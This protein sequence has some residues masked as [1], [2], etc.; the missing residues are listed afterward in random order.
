MAAG[1]S[2]RLAGDIKPWAGHVP[3]FNR[4]FDA[5]V[6]PAC[7][8]HRG[9][10]AVEH[11]PHSRR[12]ACGDERQRQH[13]H[14]PDI[15]LAMDGVDVAIDQSWHQRAPAAVDDV[16]VPRLDRLVAEFL[17]RVALRKQLVAA[18]KFAERW[19]KQFE[20]SEQDWPRHQCSLF[21]WKRPP[22]MMTER[23][24]PSS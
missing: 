9:E 10:S 1:G 21:L 19:F 2:D 12:R 15:D 6:G 20:I 3:G 18:T 11:G 14:E 13:L 17:D 4:G 16:S 24:R 5:P 23:C 8:A 7:V 22:F